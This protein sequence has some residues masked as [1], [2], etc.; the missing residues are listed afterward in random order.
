MEK[1][2][3]NRAIYA[4]IIKKLQAVRLRPQRSKIQA[5]YD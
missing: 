4:G 3:I 5:A 1:T 2:K